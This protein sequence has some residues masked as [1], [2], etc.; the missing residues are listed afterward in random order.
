LEHVTVTQGVHPLWSDEPSGRDLLSFDA[1]AST[2]VDVILDDKLD[3]IALG[4]S[5]S[6]GSGKTSVLELVQ[7]AIRLRTAGSEEKVLVIATQPWRYDPAVG[8]KESLIAEVLEALESELQPGVQ[9]SAR[10]LFDKLVRRVNWAKAFKVAAKAGIALQL[11]SVEDVLGLIKE[12]PDSGEPG[13]RGLAGFREDFAELL[14]SDDLK[15]VSRVVVLVDD[16]DRCLPET[17][18]E[19]LEAIRLFLSAK[20]MSF[21][22]AADE[23]R[24]ADAIQQRLNAPAPLD[25]EVESPAKLYLHKIVQTTVP[26]PSLSRFDT[27]AYLFL[28]LAE[29]FV[30]TEVFEGLVSSC[31]ELRRKSGSLDDVSIPEGVDL[32]EQLAVASRLTPILYEKFRGNPR[33]IKR[34]LNDL[35]VRQSVSEK[36]GIM[37]PPDAIAKL[38]VLEKLLKPDFET[39]LSWL[40]QNKLRDRLEALDKAANAPTTSVDAEPSDD[41]AYAAAKKKPE[42]ATKTRDAPRTSD[43]PFSDTLIRWAKLPPALDATDVGAYLYLAASFA[44]IEVVDD[45]LPERLRDIASALTSSLQTERSAIGDDALRA[46]SVQDSQTLIAHLGRQTRDQPSI[47]KYSVAGMLRISKTHVG[48]DDAVAAALKLLPPAVVQVATVMLLRPEGGNVF[49]TV[50]TSWDVGSATDPV[51]NVIASVRESWSRTDGD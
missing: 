2:V 3:P 37:L 25:P 20:G 4:L 43:L 15:H 21:V 32:A 24:V 23:E 40:A 51:K 26:L 33:R 18:V 13:E 35:S 50:L 19:T 9:S 49:G 42:A 10:Q 46:L 6:W 11:P 34:F 41:Q 8:P 30:Q 12:N 31:A 39:V 48:T 29:P 27:H 38:M 36:R 47:Q 14:G 22:I 44:G 28:L 7:T 1:V 17:V 5:G 45:G 16:L